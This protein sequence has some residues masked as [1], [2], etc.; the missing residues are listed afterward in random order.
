MWQFCWGTVAYGVEYGLV[1]HFNS[2]ICDAMG[3]LKV[4]L[5]GQTVEHQTEVEVTLAS[6]FASKLTEHVGH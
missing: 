2:S 6:G 1:R 5:W 4:L 3:E